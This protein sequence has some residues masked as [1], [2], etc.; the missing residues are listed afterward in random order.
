MQ[1]VV[2]KSFDKAVFVEDDGWS[3]THFSSIFLPGS[4][5]YPYIL[6]FD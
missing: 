6:G 5:A 2:R 1:K 3:V 4:F